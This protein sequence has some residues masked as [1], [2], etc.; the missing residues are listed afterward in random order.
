MRKLICLGDSLTFGLRVPHSQT[1]PRIIGR[2][3]GWDVENLG[4]NGDTTGGMLVRL[5]ELV[6]NADRSLR[7]GNMPV[8]LIM[9]GSNDIF[10]AGTDT[11]A[12]AN[13][14]AMIHQAIPA[15]LVPVVGIPLPIS[16]EDAPKNWGK[17]A[18]FAACAELLEDYSQWLRAYCQAFGVAYVDFRQ[19]FLTPDGQ[20][21]RELFSDGLHPN[22]QGHALMARRLMESGVLK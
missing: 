9:G 7:P 17:V 20:V 1:W 11:G 3:T 18:D 14:G 4:I 21:R 22:A 19:D 13:I 10:Y 12:R 16:V 6:R 15:H 5:Q 2:E 8:V